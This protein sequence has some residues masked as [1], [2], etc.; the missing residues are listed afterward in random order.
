MFG[1]LKKNKEEIRNILKLVAPVTGKSMPL[2][3]VPDEVFAQKM[4]GDGVAVIPED[5]VFVAPADGELTLVFE[6]KHAFA[7]K[8]DSGIELLVHI[9]LETV[10]LKGEGFEQ[11][12]KSG[13]RI[14][15]GTPIMK[16]DR[17]FIKSKG[18]NLIT[19]V[20]ITNPDIAKSIVCLENIY[21][22]TGETTIIEYT[23]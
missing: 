3:E 21:T 8:L 16:V 18:L 1:F 22:V 7:M 13:T 19:P 2:A 23:V 9:G 6:T 5:D 14:K 10:S 4:A 17:E 15:S 11:L 12:V 20:L